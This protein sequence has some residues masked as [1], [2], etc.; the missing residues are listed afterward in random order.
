VGGCHPFFL[1][2]IHFKFFFSRVLSGTNYCIANLSNSYYIY[3][4]T[5]LEK[6]MTISQTVEIPADRRITLEVP[7]QIPAGTT[8]RFE[9]VWF[10]VRKTVNNLDTTLDKIW[11][12]CKEASFTVDS[13]LEMRRCDKDLEEK[14]YL[15]FLSGGE[16]AS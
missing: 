14:Q 13:F 2:K 12:L 6:R 16:A 15:Q 8:A 1:F 11:I 9:L 4:D 3:N 10:P 5:T 7:A